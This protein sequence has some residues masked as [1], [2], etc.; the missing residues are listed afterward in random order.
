MYKKCGYFTLFGMRYRDWPL[1]T[2]PDSTF[3][4]TMVPMSLIIK[5]L[6]FSMIITP[7]S[8]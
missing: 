3:P 7:K 4:S 5:K 8:E 2:T 6:K 1:V